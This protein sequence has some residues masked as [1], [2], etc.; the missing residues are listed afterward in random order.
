MSFSRLLLLMRAS[1]KKDPSAQK[2]ILY[3]SEK[4]TYAM[5]FTVTQ[6]DFHRGLSLLSHA[7]GKP[8]RP[9]EAYILAQPAIEERRVRLSARSE[10]IGMHCWIPASTIEAPAR[11]LLP[12]RLLSDVVS[13][14]PP[15]P[16]VLT[17]PSPADP[18]SC[19]LHCQRINVHMKNAGLDPAEFPSIASFADDGDVLLQMDTEL[20]K[21]ILR[22]VTF[23]AAGQDAAMPGLIGVYL[24]IAHGQATFAAADSYR[25]A[26]R[27][28]RIPDE[29]RHVSLLLPAQ[30]LDV[31][32]KLLP[33]QGT[34]QMQLTEDQHQIVFH[35]HQMDV[36]MRLL[37]LE[38]PNITNGVIPH[39]WTTR[40]ILPT[41][42]LASLVR[43]MAPFARESKHAIRVK[44]TGAA[45][46][47]PDADR[48]P[49]TM[50]L[51][52]VAQD[53]GENQNDLSA[54]VEGPDQEIILHAK[55]LSDVLA[56]ITT[57]QIALEV[58]SSNRPT[59]IRP[60]GGN[61][62][63]YVLAPITLTQ[64]AAPAQAAAQTSAVPA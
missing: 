21:G 60:V 10:E 63:R 6:Q 37:N 25:L 54:Q 8:T 24:E 17:A 64:T 41:R 23:A 19:H 44:L 27:R 13:N 18:L 39:S 11:T 56:V 46:A 35:T 40:A 47:Q 59:V 30:T 9:I 1:E 15:A 43:L 51:E 61:D 16:V 26:V 22:E 32:A 36:S 48:E 62:Y 2:A 52:V 3:N 34:V 33:Y 29:Q 50:T 14:L 28:L 49:N 31:L 4:G 7:L 42:E 5:R 20:L 57:P 55:Y 45:S 58:I 12:A 53:V 38:F